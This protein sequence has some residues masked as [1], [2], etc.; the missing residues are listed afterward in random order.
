MPYGTPSEGGAGAEYF[1][2]AVLDDNEY[3]TS[4]FNF[5]F[6]FQGLPVSELTETQ[7]DE[8]VEDLIT[9]LAAYPGFVSIQAQKRYLTVQAITAETP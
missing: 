4:I 1:G 3:D 7:K 5:Q 6:T 2:D 8:I 9:Y